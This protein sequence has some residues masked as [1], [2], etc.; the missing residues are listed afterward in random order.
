[1]KLYFRDNFFSAGVTEIVDEVHNPAG[2]LNLKS[3]FNSAVDVY[4]PDGKLA[5]KGAFRFFSSRWEVRD[6]REETL[7]VL[8]ARMSF[9]R[10]KFTYDTEG[11]G[12]YEITSPAFS[13]EYGVRDSHGRIVAEFQRVNGW[14]ES[15]AYCLDNRSDRLGD[16]ELV[17]V[18][19]G[20]NNL[21]K[22]AMTAAVT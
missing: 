3:A 2:E 21:H 8:R 5:C 1:M 4:D 20:M 11:R 12:S 19:M 22:S 16:Y 9:F 13:R 10:K 18:I 17:C 14:F 7:G 15:G 6:A